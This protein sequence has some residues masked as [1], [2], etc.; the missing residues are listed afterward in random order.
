MKMVTNLGAGTYEEKLKKAGLTSLKERRKRGDLIEAYKTLNGI[1]RVKKEKWFTIQEAD[2]HRETR[3]NSTVE[4]GQTTKK[5][6][7]LVQERSNLEVR[8]NFYTVRV[9]S[10]WNLLPEKVKNQESLN[11]F[12]NSLDKWT[13]E[14]ARRETN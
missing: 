5:E 8:R 6:N 4:E 11:A 2:Q 13:E 3:A 12:K 7:V 1:N 14:E 10:Q 9:V